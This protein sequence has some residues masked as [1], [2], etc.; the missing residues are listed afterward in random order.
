MK[1]AGELPAVK[2]PGRLTERAPPANFSSFLF[3]F[4]VLKLAP[5]EGDRS[6]TVDFSKVGRRTGR[7][8][9]GSRWTDEGRSKDSNSMMVESAKLEHPELNNIVGPLAFRRT[10]GLV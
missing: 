6:S 5:H 8:C 10:A 4:R 9:T 3:Y 2:Q 7:R 1:P